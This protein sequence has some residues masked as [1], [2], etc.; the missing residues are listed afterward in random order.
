[1]TLQS[2]S[3]CDTPAKVAAHHIFTAT[4]WSLP[5]IHVHCCWVCNTLLT[6]TLRFCMRASHPLFVHGLTRHLCVFCCARC[7]TR[8][9]YPR[10][11]QLHPPSRLHGRGRAHHGAQ[12]RC[13]HPR[14]EQNPSFSLHMHL[15]RY[16]VMSRCRQRPQTNASLP[17]SCPGRAWRLCSCPHSYPYRSNAPPH[18]HSRHGGGGGG[19]S[20]CAHARQ[21]GARGRCPAGRLPVRRRRRR[22]RRWRWRAG[23]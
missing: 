16:H 14:R 11:Q 15:P 10:V 17:S 18:V 6:C 3:C 9:V 13:G 2:A 12:R 21:R 4:P 7:R 20:G 19:R 1:L 22:R 8:F 23:Q 5:H